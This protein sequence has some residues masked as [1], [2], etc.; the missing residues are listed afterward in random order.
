MMEETGEISFE[1]MLDRNFEDKGRL[2]PGEKIK[3]VVFRITKE[4]IFIDLGRKSEGYI[5]S[6]EFLDSEGNISVHEGDTVE[7]Y[8]LSAKNNEMLFTVNLGGEAAR[9]HLE[10][11]FENSIPVEGYVEKEIKGGFEIKISGNIR[12]FCP[13]SQSGL[14]RND[15]NEEFLDQHISFKII[16][17]RENGRNIILSRRVILEEEREERKEA[18]K[19]TLQEGMIVKGTV[20]SIMDFGAFVDIGGVEG[21]IPISEIG[22]AR[23]TDIHE[24]LEVGQD[25]EVVILKL[26]WEAERFSFSLKGTLADPWDNVCE[27]YPEG[28]VITGNAVRL[29]KFGVF[30][31]LEPGVDGLI[32]ISKLGAGRR[33]NHPREVITEGQTVE[34]R[35][36]SV[37]VENKRISLVILSADS[38]DDEKRSDKE[39]L[40]GYIKKSAKK[41]SGSMGTLG[42]LLKSKLK[43]KEKIL[44]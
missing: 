7:A 21:L 17:Y 29:A 35:I 31:T 13:F 10:D 19:A 28:S 25:V 27:K 11:A 34:V 36:E 20:I 3:A 41:S 39:E 16:E 4:W 2:V 12:G 32:H 40:A 26:D 38:E 1:E 9:L 37:D 43:S 5:S 42:D 22:W 18:L 6:S 8:F 14:R 33:I 15:N 24:Y 23:V 30:V 44:P